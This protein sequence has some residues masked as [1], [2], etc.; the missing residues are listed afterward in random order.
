MNRSRIAR[1]ILLGIIPAIAM[2]IAAR[3]LYLQRTEDLSTWKGVGMGMFASADSSYTRFLKLYLILPN[4]QRQPLLRFTAQ[5]ELL[6]ARALWFPSE[7]NFRVLAE[8][9]KATTW[10]ANTTQ[11]PLNVFD[12]AG[13]K[14]QEGTGQ[15]RDL[16]PTQVK[17]P[18]ETRDWGVEVEYWKAD[19]EAATG[20]FKAGIARSFVF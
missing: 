14:I 4:G 15:F 2:L 3:Q 13:Q 8:S 7:R 12:E 5:Q 6:K 9:I 20:T 16:Y 11:V 19:F 1:G 17:T 10:W 18:S